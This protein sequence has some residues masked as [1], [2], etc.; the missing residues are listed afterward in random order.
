MFVRVGDRGDESVSTAR[1]RPHSCLANSPAGAAN[2][3]PASSAIDIPVSAATDIPASAATGAVTLVLCFVMGL[4]SIGHAENPATSV[5]DSVSDET[6][7]QNTN[8][9]SRLDNDRPLSQI[10]IPGTHDTCA[11]HNGLSFGF[12]KCQSWQLKDQLAAGIRFLDI[13]CRHLND[14]F[15]IYHGVIDQKMTF[16]KVQ[17]VCQRF[18]A[19]H[20]SE[21]IVMSVKQ[22][23]TPNNNTRTFAQT[24]SKIIAEHKSI[25]HLDKKVPS[26]GLV[27]GKIVL[28]DRV[29]NLGGV[30]WNATD[31]Q[32]AY[33]APLD[34]KAK[35]LVDHFEKTLES[36]D[37]T[38]YINY[39][40]GTLP[41][42]LI[43]PVQ[44]ARQTNIVAFDYLKRRKEK[45]PLRFGTVVMDFPSEQFVKLIVDSN[46]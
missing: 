6:V 8:W 42:S 27:R 45:F 21:C 33:Q 15:H 3:I 32:D 9:M 18:L 29:G 31:R 10:S 40:S 20:P 36:D 28:V 11:V 7:R 14:R 1:A 17:G 26:L 35:R 41:G 5:S 37:G 4:T 30:P 38:W 19:Q 16:E 2:D 43:T 23:S 34:V 44:Y 24:F 25:W 12:A 39:C 22:E 13:R 46:F